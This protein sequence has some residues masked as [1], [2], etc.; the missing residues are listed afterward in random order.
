MIEHDVLAIGAGPFNLG[1]AA[2]ASTV[3]DLNVAVLEAQPE[4]RWHAGLLFA[5]A[6]IRG[7]FLTDLVSLVDPTHRLSF[8]AYLADADRLYP[9]YLRDRFR[10]TR[11]EFEDYLRWVASRLPSVRLAHRVEALRWDTRLE[12]FTA[13]VMRGDGTRLLMCAKDIVLGVGTEPYVPEALAGLPG[14]R[15]VHSAEYLHRLDR[16]DGAGRVT[17]IGSGQSGAE[18]ALDLVR[19]NLDGG[20]AVSWLSRSAHTG[21]SPETCTPEYVAYFHALP[22]DRRYELLREQ[23]RGVTPG[24]LSDIHELLYSRELQPGLSEVELRT[25]VVV[26]ASTVD[27]AGR[28]VLD[29][30]HTDT[31]T[32]FQHRTDLVIAATGYRERSPHF[33][34]P[35]RQYLRRDTRG[36]PHVRLDHSAELDP[37]VSGRIF[38]PH[39][40][41]HSHGT[42]AADL[43]YGA[44]RNATIINAITGRECYRLPKN[45]AYR[46]YRIPQNGG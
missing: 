28:A 26:R 8:L 2:L 40:D 9:F 15:L 32:R 18:V 29:C 41:G 34:G 7:S 22:E 23:R 38:V 11:L 31:G 4:L 20:P 27:T 30:L 24:T 46:S 44:V 37:R 35:I 16:V 3:D 42:A 10:P 17:V 13:H 6:T 12:R 19:R 33:M 21:G 36:R 39:A 25:E 5:D 14:T 1:L 45:T 43:G